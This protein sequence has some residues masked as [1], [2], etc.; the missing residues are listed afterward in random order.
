MIRFTQDQLEDVL[1][2]RKTATLRFRRPRVRPGDRTMLAFGRRDRP[3]RRK[4]LATMSSGSTCSAI[5]G[6]GGLWGFSSSRKK[7]LTTS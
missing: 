4:T 7:L 1:A 2:G 6:T 3:G 5:S